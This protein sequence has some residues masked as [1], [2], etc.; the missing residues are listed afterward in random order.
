MGRWSRVVGP[1][2]EREKLGEG[3]GGAG[4]EKGAEESFHEK[5]DRRRKPGRSP[6]RH[7]GPKVEG[8]APARVGRSGAG[9]TF[10]DGKRPE[11]VQRLPVLVK[12]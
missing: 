10:S 6:H 7:A 2:S 4:G 3:Y 8:G 9:C 12:S 5:G 1:E 11:A